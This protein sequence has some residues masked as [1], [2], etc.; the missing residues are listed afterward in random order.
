MRHSYMS[1]LKVLKREDPELENYFDE[2][3]FMSKIDTISSSR[4]DSVGPLDEIQEFYATMN[5]VKYRMTD[6]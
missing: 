5:I 3:D 4:Y 2:E 6:P 1:S